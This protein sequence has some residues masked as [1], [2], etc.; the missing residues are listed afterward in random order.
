MEKD[1]GKR[2]QVNK[3]RRESDEKESKKQEPSRK[4]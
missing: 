1:S 4:A 3:E 2:H